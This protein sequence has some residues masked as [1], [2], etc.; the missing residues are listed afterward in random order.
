MK[1]QDILDKSSVN[2]KIVIKKYLPLLVS[3]AISTLTIISILLKPG[4]NNPDG[5]V[6]TYIV[7]TNLI[8]GFIG[9]AIISIL[10]IL[11]KEIWSVLFIL[12]QLIFFLDL[13]TIGNFSFYISLGPITI[14]LTPIPFVLTHLKL[15]KDVLIKLKLKEPKDPTSINAK[16]ESE[17][18]HFNTQIEIF[19]EKW[20]DKSKEEL[21]TIIENNVHELTAIEAAKQLL[22]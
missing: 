18:K 19:K 4:I 16:M 8:L 5:S 22:K 14:N 7:Q 21:E 3:L 11:K 10:A 17:K 12:F 2:R 20:K 13:V 9:L 6:S 1:N 15:N